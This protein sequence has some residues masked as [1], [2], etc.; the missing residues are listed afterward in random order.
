LFNVDLPL[1]QQIQGA[2]S[3][4]ALQQYCEAL[5][6]QR[7]QQPQDDLLS[8]LV[9]AQEEDGTSLSMNELV[10]L[11]MSFLIAGHLTT[12]DLIGNALVLLL[13][14]PELWQ[15]LC[16]EP[17]L[18]PKLIEETLRRDSSVP[19]LMRVATED[20][21]FKGVSITKGSRLFLAFGS[22]NHDETV[23]PN[24]TRF[25]PERENLHKHLAFG[26][27]IHFCI[28]APVARLEGRIALEV[29]SQRLPNLR[30]QPGQTVTYRP[31]LV[32]RGPEYLH[33]MW[34]HENS[35]NS[36]ELREATPAEI[37]LV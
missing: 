10:G 6:E 21:T 35:G 7:R 15:A 25:E 20:M 3:A 30:F 24:P 33:L 14:Q 13:Q 17:R 4:V 1:E 19:G 37:Q 23:F 27:G 36:G 16:Y 34:D 8:D 22:A 31:N 29:L 18:A 12:S 11:I 26:Q 2:R 9:Q 32:F 5:I 28:G